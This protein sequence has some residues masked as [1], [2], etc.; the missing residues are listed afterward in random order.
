LV[1]IGIVF[2]TNS[3]QLPLCRS[4]GGMSLSR[5]QVA[6]SSIKSSNTKIDIV[7]NAQKPTTAKVKLWLAR[8]ERPIGLV[9]LILASSGLCMV[10]VPLVPGRP[11]QPLRVLIIGRI[12]T[13]HQREESIEASYEYVKDFLKRIYHGPVAI[14]CLG[15]QASGMVADRQTIREAEDLI[16]SGKIDVLIVEDVGRIY[17][18]SRHLIAFV[19]DTVDAGV[20]LIAI[21][22]TLDTAEEDW[23]IVHYLALAGGA[24]LSAVLAMALLREVRLRRALQKLLLRILSTWRRSREPTSDGAAGRRP[25]E[26]DPDRV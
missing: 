11:G 22:D 6:V 21:N 12:S 18:E 10:T 7:A 13:P 5:V 3:A 4:A 17:R 26:L 23:E 20:R 14:T 2:S 9:L 15:E 19:H 8:I 16:A 24:L 25:D 1:L